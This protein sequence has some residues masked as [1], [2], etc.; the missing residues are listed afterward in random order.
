MTTLITDGVNLQDPKGM[1]VYG[2]NLYILER[3]NQKILQLNLS[4]LALTTVVSTG[5]TDPKQMTV[6]GNTLYW[7][8]KSQDEVVTTVIGVWSVSTFAGSTS[9]HVNATGTSAKF[10]S[11]EGITTDGTSLYVSDT[12]NN[13]IRKIDISTGAVSS[14]AGPVPAGS[15]S[16]YTNDSTSSSARFDSP[17]GITSDGANL[18]VIDKNNE[19]VRKVN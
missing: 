5:I 14:V 9:G 2:N 15:T 11:P 13:A 7:V 3:S 8:D 16:G 18:F 4:T 6:A 17:R 1:A 12:G 10:N 19:T